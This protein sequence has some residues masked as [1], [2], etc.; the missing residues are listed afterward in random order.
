VSCREALA[1]G[2]GT[3][4]LGSVDSAPSTALRRATALD[5]PGRSEPRASALVSPKL[6]ATHKLPDTGS[7]QLD[8]YLPATRIA[9]SHS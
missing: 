3:G 6:E 2:M 5:P 7:H 9:G 4:M 1:S 8:G